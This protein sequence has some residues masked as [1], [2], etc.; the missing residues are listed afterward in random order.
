MPP[1]EFNIRRKNRQPERLGWVPGISHVAGDKPP[2]M[3][4]RTYNRLFQ[5]YITQSTATLGI[6][7]EQMGLMTD[8]LE[9][10]R[11]R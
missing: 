10:M 5:E 8:R 2:R 11:L 9:G 6:M 4:W 1:L 3:H 7:A